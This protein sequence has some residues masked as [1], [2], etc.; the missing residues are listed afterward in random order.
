VK[1]LPRAVSPTVAPRAIPLAHPNRRSREAF[2]R[3][4]YYADFVV[5][6]PR[7]CP[8]CHHWHAHGHHHGSEPRLFP[9]ACS[10][11]PEPPR[12]G[13]GHPLWPISSNPSACRV[14]K[15][16][17][18]PFLPCSRWRDRHDIRPC[19]ARTWHDADW[20]GFRNS[21]RHPVTRGHR[22]IRNPGLPRNK[23]CALL[24]DQQRLDRSSKFVRDDR[25]SRRL[26]ALSQ[27]RSDQWQVWKSTI[28]IT[29]SDADE[30]ISCSIFLDWIFLFE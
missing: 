30:Q 22:S 9:H 3:R 23:A 19:L 20:R 18:R 24:H 10:R 29:G 25:A 4:R 14:E 11:T 7:C 6:F 13:F 28:T 21:R 27:V 2:L 5:S 26:T 1:R 16:Q 17:E 12:L 15:T 8:I